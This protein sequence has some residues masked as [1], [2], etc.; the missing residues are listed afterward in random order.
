LAGY[1]GGGKAEAGA[2][3]FYGR[4]LGCGTGEDDLQVVRAVQGFCYCAEAVFAPGLALRG[5]GLCDKDGDRLG[6]VDSLLFEELMR[7][8][9]VFCLGEDL[10]LEEG[11]ILLELIEEGWAV[12]EEFEDAEVVGDLA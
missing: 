11:W 10:R 1:A 12:A 4:G 9:D 2:E 3:G 6:L 5:A 7:G 8:V